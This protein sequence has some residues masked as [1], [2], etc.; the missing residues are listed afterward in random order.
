MKRGGGIRVAHRRPIANTQV[1]IVEA[2]MEPVPV[3]V[4]GEIYIG[5]AGVARG[6][7]NRPEL[8][9]ERFVPDPY[10]EDT[11]KEARRSADVPDGRSGAVERRMGRSSSWGGTI[12]G[13]DARV[14]DRAGRD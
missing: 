8:T 3:G 9:A 4:V 2:E 1:Y 13:E 7:V 6:Y 5:G 11:G 10:I 12:S 14:P